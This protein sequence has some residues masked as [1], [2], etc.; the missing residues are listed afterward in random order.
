MYRPAGKY[1][2]RPNTKKIYEE[3]YGVIIPDDYEV[4]HILPER[5]G[6]THDISNLT[7][8]HWT[9]HA[10]AHLELYEKFGD[11]RDLCAYHMISGRNRDAHLVAC[12]MGGKK[13]Q[14][15]K[16]ARGELNGFQLF[17][18][19]KRRTVAS[20]A[21]SISGLKQKE[22]GLGI[23]TDEETRREW[24]RL[25][26]LAVVEKNGF[27]DPNR[28][29]ERGRKGGAKNK[30]ARWY[31]DGTNNLRY[32]VTQQAE[33]PFDEFLKRTGMKAGKTTNRTVGARFYNDGVNQFMFVQ[34]D[35]AE[36]F[37]E[38]LDNNGFKQG[39][40]K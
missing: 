35:H 25:G 29:A 24:A 39:R 11:P 33:E 32:T 13:S 28:Q 40:L 15:A 12:S 21:G 30:G 31:N 10:L 27:T 23:H 14:E 37:E 18:E 1:K 22:L 20:K 4:H 5:L 19:A 7:V 2:Y 9:D 3:H 36:S 16:K 8:L 26:A 34:S 6:G 17:D 38:F